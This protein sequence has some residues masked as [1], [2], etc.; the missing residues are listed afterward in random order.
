MFALTSGTTGRAKHIPIT[1]SFIKSYRRGWNIWGSKVYSDHSE[2]H[3]RKIL[4]VSS[5]CQ[6]Y[7][8]EANIPCGAI[9]GMLAHNQKYI[10]RQL[11]ATPFAVSEIKNAADRYYTIM[12]FAIAQDIAFI[13]TANPSTTLTL[14]RT[15]ESCAER[16]IRD[17]HDGTLDESVSLAKDL[18]NELTRR[19]RSERER[20]QELQDLLDKHGRLLPKYYW[21]LAFLANW[22]GGSLSL[23]LPRLSEYYGTVPIRDIGL[24]AS[25]GRMSIPMEDS[26]TAGVLDIESN[27]YQ[28]VPKDEI[29]QLDDPCRG[30]TVGE[31]LTTLQA[32][33]LEKG[34]QYYIFL[35]NFAGL[36]RYNIG[37]LI[38]VA[39]HIG[40]TPII[41][42]LS[43]GAHTSSMTGE[44]L[45][46]NQVVDAV[47]AVADQLAI[48]IESFIMVPQWDDPPR[49][50]L[51]FESV[52][53][54]GHKELRRMAQMI[55][56]RLALSNMEY[57][58][59]RDS[60]RLAPV[61]IR[62]VPKNFLAERDREQ[63]KTN[64]GRSEQFKHRFLYNEPVEL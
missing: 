42:F 36:Y 23:Y 18:R 16:L 46:E 38:R 44:K 22:T 37:D 32:C 49:Y 21:D 62:E 60:N 53:P 4:H 39:D 50:R 56:M 31:N 12:R 40:T 17:V 29:D 15:A 52:Q 58:S 8:T 41:E 20:A 19:L 30:Q 45:T 13:S 2:A 7:K 3:L 10:V 51:F 59:K 33:Q 34:E 55:D 25:E 57:E 47:H 43:K 1:E 9:S 28:F 35:T 26:T 24:L 27:F 5:S 6:E 63:L 11:Y 54:L 61:E 14:A 48:S 64:Q